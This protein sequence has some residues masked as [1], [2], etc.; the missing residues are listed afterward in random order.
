[1]KPGQE[2]LDAATTALNDAMNVFES[3][4]VTTAALKYTVLA[5]SDTSYDNGQTPDGITTMTVKSGVAGFKYF[6]VSVAPVVP[7][8]GS[9]VVV[10]VLSR[11]GMQLAINATKADFDVISSAQAGFNIQP[12]DVV[13]AYIVD[14]LTNAIDRNPVIL[15]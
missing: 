6:S 12:G 2:Q 5:N 10:F 4:K 9:E 13:K 7:H 14:D 1:M 3:G 11:S 15:Q 8:V